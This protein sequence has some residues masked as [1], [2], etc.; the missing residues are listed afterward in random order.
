M[1]CFSSLRHSSLRTRSLLIFLAPLLLLLPSQAADSDS[2]W[3]PTQSLPATIVRSS[4]LHEL[5]AP[6]PAFQMMLQS[7]AGLAAKSVNEHRSDELLWLSNA[8]GDLEI[9]FSKF[10][11]QHPTIQQTG[12]LLPW[13]LV[14]HFAKNHLIKGYIL[15]RFD[16]STGPLNSYRPAMDCSVNVATG[17]A[18]ILHGILIDESLEKEA[19]SHGLTLLLDARNKSQQWCF[20]TYKAQFNRRILCTQDPKKPH[21]RALAIAQNAFTTY[22]SSEPLSSVMAWLEPLSPILGWNGG[23]EFESTDLSSLFGQFQTASD[24]CMNLPVLMAGSESITNPPP[25]HIFDPKKIDWNDSRSAVSFISTDGDNVQWLQGNFFHHPNYWANPHRGEIPFGWSTCFAHL[26]QLSPQAIDY[27][28]ETQTANDSFIEWGGGYYYP[29]HFARNRSSRWDL[30][31]THARRTWHL[32]QKSHTQ[33]IGFN[34]T[35]FDSPDTRRACQVFASQTDHLLGILLF[36][37]APYE[38]GAGNSFWVKD[39]LGN[40]VPV[41]SARYS[42]WEHSNDRRRS[43]TPA[44]VAREIIQTIQKKPTTPRYDW[45]ITHAWSWFKKAPGPDENAENIPQQ[46]AHAQGAERGYTPVTWC[47]ERLPSNIR[48][49][50]PEE[51]LWRLRMQHNPEETKKLLAN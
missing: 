46:N 19:Q 42:I 38:A 13:E 22:G 10:L 15:Y 9:F 27:A 41:L 29:D 40:E 48:V 26:S 51:L 50:L 47:A 39:S 2:R 25:Q 30:L 18:P 12:P 3:W 43:G 21:A 44:K 28:V 49:V 6:Q 4:N 36:Q 23:D 45:I 37:Y 24:W 14:E 33:I 20:E 5:P 11:T 31:A 8:S 32:M 16:K 35:K 34:V 7:I 1:D 17:L